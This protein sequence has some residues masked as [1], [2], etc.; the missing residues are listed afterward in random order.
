MTDART[1]TLA[2]GGKWYGRY[3]LAFCPAHRNVRTPA[4]SLADG[5]DGRLLAS[6][7]AGC[8]FA[9]ILDA[10]RGR[11]LMEERGAF[12]DSGPFPEREAEARR[13]AE[14][15]KRAGQ[16]HRLW[17]E[18]RPIGGT[19]AERYLRG[20]G[21]TCPLAPSLR[22][23]PSCWHAT[24]RRFPALVA[25]V[26][27]AEG[28]AVHRTY[29]RAD[30]AGKA[31]VEP[32]KAMLG[33]VQGG[34]VRLSGGPGPLVVAEG[35]ETALSLASGLLGGPA[36]VWAALSTSGV[37]GLRLPPEPGRLII[38]PDGD[39]AG[40]QAAHDLAERAHALGWQA[41]LLPAPEGRDWNDM[42]HGEGVLA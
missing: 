26:E 37:R 40:R 12:A 30:G 11:A 38:A 3:G 17:Q 31:E 24:A 21:I 25:L 39:R 10:L 20:R 15:E 23:H 6:C 4:L 29:L 35:I 27:G 32:V 14:A 28:F 8:T 7:K 42:L 22:F 36:A 33:A 1:L 2:L 18:A 5:A 13:K 19:L 9:V 16:A 34:G 41:A